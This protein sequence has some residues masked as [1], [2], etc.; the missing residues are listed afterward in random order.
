MSTFTAIGIDPGKA[1]G[2]AWIRDGK[3]CA[4]KMPETPADLVELLLGIAN[5]GPCKAVLEHVRSSPQ[6][7]VVSAFTFGRG[8]GWLEVAL[9]ACGIPYKEVTPA[10]WM[11]SLS[12]LTKGDKHITKIKAQQLFPAVKV[13]NIN[14]DALLIAE[15]CRTNFN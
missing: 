4:E 15:Y 6:M 11:K 2:I 10:T 13:T 5:E 8:F 3:A 1:G 7:G 9:T 12:C 14:A